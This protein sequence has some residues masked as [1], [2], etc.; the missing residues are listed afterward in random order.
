MANDN[1]LLEEFPEKTR[2]QLRTLWG[3]LPEPL[4]LT[5]RGAVKLLPGDFKRWRM[6]L[7]M[8]LSQFKIAAGQK[9]RV[10]IVGPANAGKSTLY[11]QFV[12]EQKD[13]ALVSPVPGTTREN[14]EADAGL[15]GIVDTPGADAVGEIGELEKDRALSAADKADF[16]VLVFDATQ[17]I[18]KSEQELYREFVGLEKPVVVVLNKI[19]LVRKERDKVVAKAAANLGLAMYQVIPISAKDGTNL[20]R[21]MVAIAK[22]EPEMVA[23]LGRALPE[24]RWKLAWTAITGAASTA[25]VIAL[26]PLPI[27][28]VIPLLAVQI[29][30][31][32]GIARIYKYEITWER[33]RELI[34]TFGLGFLGR[35]IF[36]ELSKI[37]GPPG[38]LISAAIASSTTA[39]MGYAAVLW[40]E[41]GERLTGETMK[42]VTKAVTAYLLD[43][44]RSLG[45]RKPGNKGLRDRM[46]AA[47]EKSQLASGA[48]PSA[49]AAA[50]LEGP[51]PEPKSS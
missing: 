9:H 2:E 27:F 17:G 20:E 37:G 44:L 34:V 33:A 10:A 29:S 42:Q 13:R 14:Q 25:A 38:W 7:G 18:R 21:V 36:Q 16:L 40:F 43:S 51:L 11:N 19:D 23:A 4:Q 49:D 35:S 45:Q 50:P 22:T 12:R 31:V 46:A 1:D 26:T 6:L 15:F 41:R 47:L 39:V 32:L 28:D 24:Y 8:A 5:L 3:D 30:M 48:A